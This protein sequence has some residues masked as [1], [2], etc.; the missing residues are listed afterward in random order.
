M[1]GGSRSDMF[2][3][4]SYVI[5]TAFI[6]S[7]T[8]GLLVLVCSTLLRTIEEVFPGPSTSVFAGECSPDKDNFI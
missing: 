8:G 1:N 5:F 6:T 2:P 3:M 7:F 4:A